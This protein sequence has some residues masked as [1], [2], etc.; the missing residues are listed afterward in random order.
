M[1]QKNKQSS[2]QDNIQDIAMQVGTVAMSGA[3]VLGIAQLAGVN[4]KP[5]T[6][7]VVKAMKMGEHHKEVVPHHTSYGSLQ[8]TASRSG[9]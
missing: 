3:M 4:S 5:T 2:I 9:A 6:N 8:R 7:Y 1:S